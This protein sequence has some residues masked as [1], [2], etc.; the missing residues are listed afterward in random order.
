MSK[1]SINFIRH[2]GLDMPYEATP[3]DV[4]E[5]V[6]KI[7]TLLANRPISSLIDSPFVT[8]EKVLFCCSLLHFSFFFSNGLIDSILEQAKLLMET[9]RMSVPGFA[10]AS[11]KNLMQPL[12]LSILVY[13]V[14]LKRCFIN[15]ET[16]S[17]S[18]LNL[19]L[20]HSYR[21]GCPWSM[22]YYLSLQRYLYCTH[23]MCAFHSR[24][25][26]VKLMSGAT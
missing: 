12:G 10:F 24:R 7:N 1:I 2:L 4:E 5:E 16:A 9:I 8:D 6:D 17:L 23:T 18:L 22:A 20:T 19:H 14:F 26:F 3:D 13:L 15:R 21:C 25:T 11:N